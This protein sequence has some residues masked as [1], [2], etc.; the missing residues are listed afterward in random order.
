[1][2]LSRKIISEHN[3]INSRTT[4]IRKGQLSITNMCTFNI[5]NIVIRHKASGCQRTDV[6]IGSLSVFQ[7][8]TLIDFEYSVSKTIGEGASDYWHFSCVMPDDNIYESKE[9][10]NHNIRWLDNGFLSICIIPSFDIFLFA[11]WSKP[12]TYTL[13]YKAPKK[14]L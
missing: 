11:S 12:E 8:S 7:S 5:R 13:T 10:F 14:P 2:P 9:Y 3:N 6:L 1:M 4:T